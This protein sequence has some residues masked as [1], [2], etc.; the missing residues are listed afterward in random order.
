MNNVRLRALN[1]EAQSALLTS[2]PRNK[3]GTVVSRALLRQNLRL[4]PHAL[5]KRPGRRREAKIIARVSD[6]VRARGVEIA[7]GALSFDD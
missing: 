6:A 4:R 3:K 5:F 1:V 2:R 7:I